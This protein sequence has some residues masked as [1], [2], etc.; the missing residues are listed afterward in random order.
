[1]VSEIVGRGSQS[2]AREA[3][4]GVLSVA[5]GPLSPPPV[6]FESPSASYS[7]CWGR[8]RFQISYIL[9]ILNIS[10]LCIMERDIHTQES[11][12]RMERGRGKAMHARATDGAAIDEAKPGCTYACSHNSR[13]AASQESTAENDTRPGWAGTL[14]TSVDT[15]S[16]CGAGAGGMAKGSNPATMPSSPRLALRPRR[17]ARPVGHAPDLESK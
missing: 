13:Q 10:I 7:I 6:D 3:G 11:R 14:G 1:M 8:G 17:E 16:S 5:V 12:G 15:V 2:T 9:G 4:V